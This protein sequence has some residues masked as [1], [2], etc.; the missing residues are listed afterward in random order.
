MGMR[1]A[2]AAVAVLW[3]TG[4]LLPLAGL[5]NRRQPSLPG[6]PLFRL[7]LAMVACAASIWTFHGIPAVTKA[8][9]HP[10]WNSMGFLANVGAVRVFLAWLTSGGSRWWAWP[11]I[12][13]VVMIAEA[14]AA[15][16]CAEVY[17]GRLL[18]ARHPDFT[19]TPAFVPYTA[20]ERAA[21]PTAPPPRQ[22]PADPYGM[23]EYVAP[24]LDLL[25]TD[26]TSLGAYHLLSGGGMRL[27]RTV[28]R[29]LNG[30][31]EARCQFGA[32]AGLALGAWIAVSTASPRL[33]LDCSTAALLAIWLESRIGRALPRAFGHRSAILITAE[34]SFWAG[35]TTHAQFQPSTA[36]PQPFTRGCTLMAP[37]VPLVIAAR[38]LAELRREF[39]DTKPCPRCAGSGSR[40]YQYEVEAAVKGQVYV[41][42]GLY[43]N[44]YWQETNEIVKPARYETRS[45]TCSQCSGKGTVMLT[46]SELLRTEGDKLARAR[47]GLERYNREIQRINEEVV[48]HNASVPWRI[49][50]LQAWARSD[51]PVDLRFGDLWPHL[52]QSLLYH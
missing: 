16:L 41:S 33:V 42:Y 19:S 14:L 5:R 11:A 2:G 25:A 6:L 28:T 26:P 24:Y 1:I 21:P 39:G 45:E 27:Q 50:V 36:A 51:D 37:A 20:S 22:P 9:K 7:L 35:A 17:V 12:V 52:E 30:A 23:V 10:N 46:D 48:R 8:M 4:A 29:A 38:S 31:V 47:P 34:L 3:C 18:A 49:S 43:G 44:G 40:E 32:I 13:L 15:R